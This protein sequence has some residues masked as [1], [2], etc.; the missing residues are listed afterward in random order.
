MVPSR[1][2]SMGMGAGTG[3]SQG[4][5][6]YWILDS[7]QKGAHKKTNYCNT[8]RYGLAQEWGR[9]KHGRG[10]QESKEWRH[11]P[12]RDRQLSCIFWKNSRVI[13]YIMVIFCVTQ[14]N[15]VTLCHHKTK[16]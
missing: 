14:R 6:T 4:V 13:L 16:E 5:E 8:S 1:P 10:V 12:P 2:S 15:Y 3:N 11:D 7:A 9:M